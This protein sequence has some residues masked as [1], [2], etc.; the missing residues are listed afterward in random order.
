MSPFRQTFKSTRFE[1]LVGLS[2]Q[3]K[4]H[5]PEHVRWNYMHLIQKDKSPFSVFDSVQHFL[6]LHGSFPTMGDHGVG[7]DQYAAE[8]ILSFLTA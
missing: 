7:C 1:S 2:S 5:L 8:N 4:A 3:R 6:R